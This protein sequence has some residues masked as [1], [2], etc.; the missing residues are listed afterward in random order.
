MEISLGVLI[1]V[2]FFAGL[3]NLI[4]GLIT[5]RFGIKYKEER[6]YIFPGLLF[7]LAGL[8]WFLLFATNI[9]NI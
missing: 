4:A 2:Q 3:M 8:L 1:V 7:T 9:M 5:L 6:K